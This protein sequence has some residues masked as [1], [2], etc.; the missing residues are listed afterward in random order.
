MNSV[1]ENLDSN[2]AFVKSFGKQPNWLLPIAK[3]LQIQHQQGQARTQAPHIALSSPASMWSWKQSATQ[4]F[5][6]S[7]QKNYL[8]M[9]KLQDTNVSE[10]FKT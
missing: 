9:E 4:P 1:V 6:H 8:N 10:I 5:T 2:L 3:A 7:S